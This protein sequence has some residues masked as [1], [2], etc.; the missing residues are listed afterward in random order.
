MLPVNRD[1]VLD[2]VSHLNKKSV[3]LPSNNARPWE[4]P[5]DCYHVLGVAKP[6]HILQ[7]DLQILI[8]YRPL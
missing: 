7:R 1:I 4:L 6:C 8:F 3:A 2:M 5:I